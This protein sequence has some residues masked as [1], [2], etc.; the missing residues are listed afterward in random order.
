MS[1]PWVQIPPSPPKITTI[2]GLE[3]PECLDN[4]PW[5]SLKGFRNMAPAMFKVG[6]FKNDHLK[7]GTPVQ[8]RIIGFNH[9]KDSSGLLVPMTWE[10]VDCMPQR[11]PWN[12]ND[13]NEGSWPGTQ[14]CHRMNDRGGDIY[15]LM[16][17]ELVRLATPVVKLTAD[18]YNGENTIIESVCKFWIK[19]EKETFGRCF[20]SAPG[21]GHWYEYYRQEDVPWQKKRNG[22][23][24]YTMLRSPY[25]AYAFCFVHT[26][27]NA[28]YG[29]AASSF[30]LAPA[31]GL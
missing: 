14:L 17:D 5:S 18:T 8:F 16:P 20:Y 2:G 11:Y 28:G 22:N 19:S 15:Q 1:R 13:T 12:R 24:E 4:F 3:M 25:D 26:N 9:D 30:G 27:G 29:I 6:D 23:E 31:F 7:D 10:M 21:E